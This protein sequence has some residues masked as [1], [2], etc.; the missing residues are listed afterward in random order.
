MSNEVALGQL[1]RTDR[2]VSALL[3]PLLRA[4]HEYE[5]WAGA[6]SNERVLSA[7]HCDQ[8]IFEVIHRHYK[9]RQINNFAL[10]PMLL[11]KFKSHVTA[12]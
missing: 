7:L 2:A 9:A 3:I 5:R 6:Q 11:R 10:P 12:K 4:S 1:P 8:Q